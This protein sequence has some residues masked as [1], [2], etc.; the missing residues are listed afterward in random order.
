MELTGKISAR[1]RVAQLVRAQD[2]YPCGREF[3][4]HPWYFMD[5]RPIGIFDSGVGGL[6]ILKEVKKLLPS[7]NFIF[8]AD[9]G[10]VP[11]GGKTQKQLQSYA[12]KIM[13]FL[14]QKN[15]KAVIVACNT[16]TVY[17]IDFLREK[18]KIPIIGTVPVVKTIANIT[19]TKKTAVFSTPATVKSP[20]L[21][22]LITKFAP[23]VTVYKIGGTGLEE[24]VETGDLENKKI[25]QILHQ[26]LEPLL[27]KNV[28][29]IALGCTH[30]PFLRDKIEEIVGKNVQVVDS[31][32]A[33]ARRTKE[34]LQENKILS[35][36]RTEDFY[37][38]TGSKQKFARA[39]KSLLKKSPRNINAI[40]I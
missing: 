10:N 12:D 28:D 30:Y 23:N 7:E 18:Y 39:V 32:G 26:L 38:T 33:V 22:K 21:Q 16:A 9:Q 15:V 6:S 17:A 29:A 8:V 4:S 5:K 13:A 19:K 20:Y 1:A 35:N 37:Y 3:E 25:D 34:I 24:L 40:I 2:S 31:G 14:M 27:K 11:Y 36:K